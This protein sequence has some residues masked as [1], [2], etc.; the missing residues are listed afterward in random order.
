MK[1]V[2]GKKLIIGIV[3][4]SFLLGIGIGV[5]AYFQ[6]YNSV[7]NQVITNAPQI[8]HYA[9]LLIRNTLDKHLLVIEELAEN[10]EIKSMVWEKQKPILDN[11]IIRHKYLRMSIVNTDGNAQYTDGTNIFLGDRE[12]FKEAMTGKSVVSDVVISRISN[13]PVMVAITPIRNYKNEI[14]SFLLATVDATWLSE[15]TD[16]IG[17]GKKGYSFVLDGK[18]N[19]IAHPN[20]DYVIKQVNIINDA[21]NDPSLAR[22]SNMMQR[23]IKGETGFDEYPY[24]GSVRIFG[25][26]PI[27]D[28]KWSIGV[29]AYKN[30]VFQEVYSTLITMIII[31]ICLFLVIT[32]LMI[33]HARSV[34]RPIQQ[35]INKIKDISEGEGDLTKKLE[36]QKND[37]A[38]DLSKH[39]NKFLDKLSGIIL[40]I[41]ESV[42]QTTINGKKLFETMNKTEISTDEINNISNEIK[43]VIINQSTIIEEVSSTIE[44][45]ARTIENQDTKIKNQSTNVRESSAAIEEMISNIQSIANNLNNSTEE[46]NNLQKVITDGNNNIEQLKKTIITLYQQSDS[47][48]EANTIIKNISS[49]TN[50]L[51]MNASIEAAH[52]GQSGRG[53]AVVADEIR[54]LAEVSDQQSKFISDNLKKLKKSIEEAVN[55]SNK[56]GQ[57]FEVIIKSVDTVT[58]LEQE[59][60]NSINEQSSGSSQILQALSSISQITEEVHIGSNEMLGSNKAVI[61]EISNLVNITE[62]VKDSAIEIVEKAKAVRQHVSESSDLLNLNMDNTKKVE[63]QVAM[64]KV[65][66][67]DLIGE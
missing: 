11:T 49:Q 41:K 50:L 48:I 53:F 46:F 8:A 16:M 14:V 27:P 30:D 42:N 26:A 38:G 9:A 19:A 56:A 1:N 62:K 18:G 66:D 15:T 12:Y 54:K 52:A 25:Y 34:V 43:E 6:A 24:L 57:S 45:I 39:F 51:A 2:L 36:I 58:N 61:S 17:Y 60:K 23:M 55:I 22:L 44:E 5:P 13:S 63:E 29:G 32:T 59:I 28:T 47:V 65:K 31:F 67:K 20:R 7:Q 21:K 3:L 10:P 33:M 4:L 35:A 37:E 64:F 40:N